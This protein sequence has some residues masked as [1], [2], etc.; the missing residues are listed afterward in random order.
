MQPPSFIDSISSVRFSGAVKN[1]LSQRLQAIVKDRENEMNQSELAKLCGMSLSRFHNYVAGTRI[2]DLDTLMRM[3]KS[4]GVTTDYLL[5]FSSA[6]PDY[7]GIIQRLLELDGM[8]QV[9]AEA[10]AEIAEEALMLS[11]ASQDDGD[12]RARSR[13]A[14]QLAWK[15]RG[16]PKPLQ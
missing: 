16:G 14:A 9:K 15:Q 13:M 8:N 3:A 11:L 12:D 1:R 6:P 2:P 10:I 7:A 5:G 4:L